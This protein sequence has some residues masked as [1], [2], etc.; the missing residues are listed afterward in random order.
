MVAEDNSYALKLKVHQLETEIKNLNNKFKMR[1][2]NYYKS[3][4]REFFPKDV[5][6]YRDSIMSTE[7]AENSIN[8][9]A[10][11]HDC[12]CNMCGDDINQRASQIADLRF[13]KLKEQFEQTNVGSSGMKSLNGTHVEGS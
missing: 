13:S 6:K 2:Q 8:S 7:A 12:C 11:A 9:G 1:N 4:V 3:V 5:E 10:K